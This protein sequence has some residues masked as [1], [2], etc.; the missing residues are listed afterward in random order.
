MTMNV[1]PNDPTSVMELQQ[2]VMAG[3]N[4]T[5]FRMRDLIVSMG[6]ANSQFLDLQRTF[7]EKT[8]GLVA[9][10]QRLAPKARERQRWQSIVAVAALLGGGLGLLW[11]TRLG[12]GF[13]EALLEALA[14]ALLT[15]F[16]IDVLLRW[17]VSVPNREREELERRLEDITENVAD[18]SDQF[19]ILEEKLSQGNEWLQEM[20]AVS[21]PTG[22][23]SP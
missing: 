19:R 6:E 15:Y 17:V 9:A 16:A 2:K 5:L 21:A 3:Q 4:D 23:P 13:G 20:A 18:A 7:R 22:L 10:A 12:H 11:S 8:D 14:V 1:D